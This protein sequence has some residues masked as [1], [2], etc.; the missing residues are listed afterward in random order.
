MC[1]NCQVRP[2][3]PAGLGRRAT[4][5]SYQGNSSSQP[6]RLG[7]E[8]IYQPSKRG[9]GVSGKLLIPI[10]EPRPS[11]QV[12]PGAGSGGASRALK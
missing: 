1:R 3:G 4:L 9:R 10:G 11:S 5:L 7:R 12:R 8:D 2:E 6:S